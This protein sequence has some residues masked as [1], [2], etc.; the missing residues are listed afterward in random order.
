MLLNLYA[1]T[2]RL[3]DKS[4]HSQLSARSFISVGHSRS[5][6]WKLADSVSV[7]APPFFTRYFSLHFTLSMFSQH[8][9][10]SVFSPVSFLFRKA[11]PVSCGSDRLS[12]FVSVTDSIS[13]G[14]AVHSR[15]FP[16]RFPFSCVLWTFFHSLLN[17]TTNKH[18]K[19]NQQAVSVLTALKRETEIIVN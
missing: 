18:I 2:G 11:S 3:M 5:W 17:L 7:R 10:V 1:L 9:Y 6:T 13:V 4:C 19:T 16:P 14:F 15:C 8:V 12:A